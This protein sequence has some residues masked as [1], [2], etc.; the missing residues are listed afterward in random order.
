MFRFVLPAVRRLFCIAR[1]V[2]SVR[3]ASIALSALHRIFI[4]PVARYRFC[5]GFCDIAVAGFVSFRSA[6]NFAEILRRAKFSK[7]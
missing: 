7:T 2:P 3:M 1:R 6:R 5:D 4:L